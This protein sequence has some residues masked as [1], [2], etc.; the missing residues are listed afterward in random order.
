MEMRAVIE[1]IEHA[2]KND[3][4]I[5]T[6]SSYIV[7]GATKWLSGWKARDWKTAQKEDV[8]NKDLWLEMDKLL[9]SKRV[10]FHRVPGH[11]GVAA[12]ERADVIATCFA[13]KK[14]VDLF[15]GKLSD[16]KV[17]LSLDATAAPGARRGRVGAAYS[18]VSLVNGVLSVDATGAECEKRVKG[19]R[20]ARFKK[21]LSKEREIVQAF[22]KLL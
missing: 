10:L 16:Y 2:K 11:S 12:N 9:S 14:K 3:I 6:D 13:D 8:M 5:Y 15:H 19:K 7:N 17:S 4:M 1:A 20:G 22:K 21:A 18:Y